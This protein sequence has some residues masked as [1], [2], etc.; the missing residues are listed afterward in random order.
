M[1]CGFEFADGHRCE[2]SSFT[3]GTDA[4]KDGSSSMLFC[5]CGHKRSMHAW[6]CKDGHRPTTSA[7]C[8]DYW[9]RHGSPAPGKCLVN[10]GKD[11]TAM[12]QMLVDHT[13]KPT[14]NW[15]R[16]RGCSLHGLNCPKEPKNCAFQHKCPV[17]NGFSVVGVKHNM[18]R[19]LWG[20]YALNCGA[21]SKECETAS[22]GMPFRKVT[23]VKTVSVLLEDPPNVVGCNEWFLFHG[24]SPANCENIAA[25]GFKLSLSGT[26]STWKDDGSRKGMPLYG[27]GV[28]FAESITKADEYS[29]MVEAG[30]PFEG[31]HTV[32]VCRVLGGR[33]QWCDTDKIDPSLLQKQVISGPF[34]SVFGDRVAKLGKP[35]RE[36]VVYDATQVYPEYVIYYRRLYGKE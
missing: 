18:N 7:P 16:D 11:I 9:S 29:E 22:G 27:D 12:F 36:M 31:C 8:P 30:Q 19:G 10:L 14:D 1:S 25:N 26:G 28:Y 4:T 17:P 34:H 35:Y 2:C 32:L 15:T 6:R 3:P 23:D 33:V 20:A 5:K 24:S 21:I 13:H